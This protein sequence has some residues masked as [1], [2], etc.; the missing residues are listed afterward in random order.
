MATPQPRSIYCGRLCHFQ[1][2]SHNYLTFLHGRPWYFFSNLGF[3]A[4]FAYE[5]K[6][7]WSALGFNL[8]IV[9]LSIEWF[10]LIYLFWFKTNI[11]GLGIGFNSGTAY[12]NIWLTNNLYTSLSSTLTV[13][14]VGSCLTQ[15]LKCALANCIGFSAILGRA[16]P[17]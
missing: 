5:R 3:G 4:L 15:A 14:A 1:P 16:G 7:V 2:H 8:L 13:T 11:R 12:N 9:C 17:L 10:F 6:L